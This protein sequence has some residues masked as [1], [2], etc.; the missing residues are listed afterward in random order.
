MSI[1]FGVVKFLLV[2]FFLF[3]QSVIFLYYHSLKF[4]LKFQNCCKAIFICQ[5]LYFLNKILDKTENEDVQSYNTSAGGIV[6]FFNSF[7]NL[8]PQ[9]TFRMFLSYAMSIVHTLKK[10]QPFERWT[11]LGV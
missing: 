6:N 9:Q 1:I 5:N 11:K 4:E 2:Y 8:A 7:R 10:S 3:V